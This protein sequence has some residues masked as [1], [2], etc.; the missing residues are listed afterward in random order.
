MHTIR[1]EKKRGKHRATTRGFSKNISS[2]VKRNLP[3]TGRLAR[4]DKPAKRGSR[5][6]TLKP[7]LAPKPILEV[8]ALQGEHS[9]VGSPQKQLK[10]ISCLYEFLI[11]DDPTFAHLQV[12]PQDGVY[13]VL[14]DLIQIADSRIKAKWK[15]LGCGDE[16]KVGICRR[17]GRDLPGFGGMP[18]Y[19][20]PSLSCSNQPLHDALLAMTALLH[21]SK[22]IGLWDEEE[23]HAIS[24]LQESIDQDEDEQGMEIE[25]K[26]MI[27]KEIQLYERGEA[28]EYLQKIKQSTLSLEQLLEMSANIKTKGVTEKK[29]HSWLKKGISLLCSPFSLPDFINYGISGE[30]EEME[31]N[32]IS[33]TTCIRFLW[34]WDGV[35][36][37]QVCDSI[38][39]N[40]GEF[41]ELPI[42][43]FEPVESYRQAKARLPRFPYQLISFMDYGRKIVA[44]HIEN[45]KI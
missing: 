18:L 35:I 32:M 39:V 23:A 17:Y 1:K 21:T 19:F 33:P 11:N 10:A 8:L 28:R 29:L 14:K 22:G 45:P 16:L 44:N 38:D 4:A 41:G 40:W 43:Y 37:E 27:E 20:L 6:S 31:Q 7:P 12:T 26:R 3:D 5:L 30:D 34:L 9:L 42:S 13:K 2:R 36:M 25:Y 15:L 24:Y